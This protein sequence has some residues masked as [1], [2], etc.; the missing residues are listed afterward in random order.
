M[1]LTIL[2]LS[3]SGLILSF[4]L[5]R[6]SIK[7]VHT[8]HFKET[9]ENNARH[10]L[11]DINIRINEIVSQLETT[12]KA[13]NEYDDF[14]HP[15]VAKILSF[16]NESN[17]F[18]FTAIAD[19]EGNGYDNAGNTFNIADREYFQTAMHGQVA[20]SEVIKSKVFDGEYVQIIAHPLRSTEN[21]V[22]GIV[23]GVF[24]IKNIQSDV[25]IKK[26]ESDNNLYIIDSLGNYIAQFRK[27][28]LSF[29]KENFWTDLK[30]RS[31][32]SKKIEQLKSDFNERKEGSFLY[33]HKGKSRYLCYMP[34]GPNKWQLIYSV[35]TD[36]LEKVLH[37]VYKLDTKNMILASICYTLLLLCVTWYFKQ[38]ND[39]IRNA[40][41]EA[42]R[43][44]ELMRIS[45]DHSK[46][47][48]FEY[49]QMLR[50]IHLKTNLRNQL[51]NQTVIHAV[52]ESFV[53]LNLIA[54]DSILMLKQLFKTI[55]TERHCEADIQIRN[56][57]REIW[58]RISMN[59]LYDEHNTIIDT[60]G[61]VEDISELKKQESEV[62]KNYNFRTS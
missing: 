40:H 54:P 12:A 9:L 55:Q 7:E 21:E 59:N 42:K 35:P 32:S 31:C 18:H 57:D 4:I 13:I 2:L 58:Y 26:S 46:H 33:S 44:M 37:S 1:F 17:W 53:S 28:K 48:V 60:V 39:K 3:I 51:F 45:M 27:N 19:A 36:S 49:D 34:I 62:Q 14:E 11:I 29:T 61:V 8:A 20:F 38:S 10:E 24:D 22:R 23:F 47:I 15:D 5:F 41:Q 50:Q 52:P 43:N 6:I 25:L 16:S 30:K 56:D